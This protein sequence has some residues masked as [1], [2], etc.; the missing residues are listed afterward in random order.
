MIEAKE[1]KKRKNSS[2]NK[3]GAIKVEVN[4][5]KVGQATQVLSVSSVTNMVI[6]QRSANQIASVVASKVEHFAK[7]F[8]I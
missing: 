4:R 1:D 3:I 7:K 2:V 5:Q 6:V 8:P